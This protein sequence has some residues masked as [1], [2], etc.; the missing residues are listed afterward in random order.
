MADLRLCFSFCS[1]VS[2]TVAAAVAAWAQSE[3]SD[4]GEQAS[5]WTLNLTF[6]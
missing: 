3:D 6:K 5:Q 1:D 2:T 4:D